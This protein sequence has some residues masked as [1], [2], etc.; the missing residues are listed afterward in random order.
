MVYSLYRELVVTAS[1]ARVVLYTLYPIMDHAGPQTNNDDSV[2]SYLDI[3][4]ASYSE[5]LTMYLE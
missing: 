1:T 4:F 3:S 2:Y 5:L